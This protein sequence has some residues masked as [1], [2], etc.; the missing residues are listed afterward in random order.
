MGFNTAD[1]AGVYR[2][3][4]EIA[5]VLTVDLFT[6]IVD[7]PYSYG[8]I[9]AANSL[10]DVYA[11]GGRPLAALNIAGFPKD[12][13]SMDV[14]AEILAGGADKAREADV[15]IIGGHTIADDELKYGLAVTGIVHP[16]RILKNNGARPGD[17]LLLTKP[18]GTGTITTALKAGADDPG[19]IAEVS[20]S[21]K[22][23][24][25]NASEIC[26]RIGVSACTD[27]SGFGL[28]GHA[29][30][31]AQASGVG[32]RLEYDRI[33]FFAAAEEMTRK[34][35]VPGGTRANLLH[36]APDMLFADRL[37]QV[38]QL[39]LSDPQT[40]GGLIVSVA[41]KKAARLASELASAG[42]KAAEIGVVV[43]QPAGKIEVV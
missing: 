21:M 5:L 23:L 42:E 31:M 43:E 19:M 28:L 14:L 12:L 3:S 36:A 10:S 33:P 1:D 6:P 15:P 25:R 17:V 13:F 24:N 39:L 29:L 40:S 8:Q 30:E 11:M 35:Y 27:V 20:E 22:R 2:L 32:L 4:D 37:G 18:L 7:D 26:Q 41:E 16:E 34:N 9:S 38:E